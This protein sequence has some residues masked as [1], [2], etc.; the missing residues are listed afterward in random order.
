MTGARMTAPEIEDGI[1]RIC[2]RF[3]DDYWSE[4]D[5]DARF[6]HE[7]HKAMAD[8]GWLGIAMPEEQRRRARLPL[9]R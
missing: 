9:R 6:P 3:G 8:A 7:F 5:T 1:A 2:A 4:C